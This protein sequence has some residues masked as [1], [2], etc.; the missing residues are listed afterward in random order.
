MPEPKIPKPNLFTRLFARPVAPL[1]AQNDCFQVE[2]D[3]LTIQLAQAP[4]LTPPGGCLRLVAE[5]LP[6]RL[7]VVHGHDGA[8][9]VYANHCACGGFHIDPVPDQPLIRCCTPA[10]STYNYAGEPVSGPAKS[11]HKCL[12]YYPV[13]EADGTLQ[14]AL[15]PLGGTTKEKDKGEQP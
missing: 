6:D 1:P 2:G 10:R 11:D 12:V 3:T 9:H 13:T 14:V 4:E 7:L 8:Y 15:Q 5:S